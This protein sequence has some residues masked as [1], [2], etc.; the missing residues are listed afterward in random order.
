MERTGSVKRVFSLVS[1]FGSPEALSAWLQTNGI[2]AEDYTA[3]LISLGLTP[4]QAAA[5]LQGGTV[6]AEIILTAYTELGD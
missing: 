3:T 4:E 6:T 1:T 2:S 5:G